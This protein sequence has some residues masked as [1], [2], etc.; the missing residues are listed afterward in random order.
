MFRP[1]RLILIG[2]IVTGLGVVAGC[3]GGYLEG[4]RSRQ[5]SEQTGQLELDV[6]RPGF[7]IPFSVFTLGMLLIASGLFRWAMKIHQEKRNRPSP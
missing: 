3:V 2:G 6:N 7:I 5:L 1:R 4:V